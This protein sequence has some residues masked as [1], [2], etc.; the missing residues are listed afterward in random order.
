[1]VAP[2]W[3]IGLA[4]AGVIAAL[5]WRLRALRTS[6][7]IAA[8]VVGTIAMGAGWD[9]GIVLVAY[10]ISSAL[11]SR[12]RSAEKENR[13]SG[14]IE[15]EG[16][17][18]AIQV[19]ANGAVFALAALGYWLHPH[20]T[21]QAL[22]AGA[23]AASAA[24]TWATEL[25]V[26]ARA[27][28]R[29]ILTWKPVSVGTSGGV[30]AQGMLAGAAGASF[31]VIITRLL[32]WPGVAAVAA[33]VGGLFGCVLD[34]VLGASLQ[35]RRWCASCAMATE[36]R[37][38]RCGSNTTVVGGYEWLDNDLVNFLA[39]FGGGVFGLFV[40]RILRA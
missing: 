31:I 6:G 21:W 8:V 36:Q 3:L 29:S 16:A 2:T 14:R 30:T 24:D 13:V 4:L 26:I 20:P 10:F 7:A 17:R 19:I 23:L 15:K 33:L 37:V 34:S 12:Y 28:P 18:D 9:W 11:L 27:T 32:R 25:G 1:M 38:H 35:A 5:A 39:T 40:A 22:G